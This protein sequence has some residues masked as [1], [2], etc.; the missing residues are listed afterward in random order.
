[1]MYSKLKETVALVYVTIRDL[2]VN[3]VEVNTLIPTE[4]NEMIR[5]VFGE[6]YVSEILDFIFIQALGVVG[7]DIRREN[8]ITTKD[9]IRVKEVSDRAVIALQMIK[10]AKRYDIYS[11]PTK[12][13]SSKLELF[14]RMITN[15]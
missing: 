1:M 4:L 13:N 5:D 14:K 2:F 3:Y 7:V 6:K 9:A 15:D 11:K 10:S 8:L 12:G